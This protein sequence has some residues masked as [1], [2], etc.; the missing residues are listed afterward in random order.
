MA[1]QPVA[2][3]P[4]PDS[5]RD[6]LRVA[7]P[8]MPVILVFSAGFGVLARASGF[9]P[10]A[11]MVM[12]LVAFGGAAQIASVGV[13]AAGGS[14]VGALAV[15]LLVQARYVPMA[16]SMADSWTGPPW[17]R[18]LGAQLLVDGAWVLSRSRRGYRIRTFLGA[19]GAHYVVWN[20]GTVVGLVAGGVLGD[21]RRLG[22]DAVIPAMFLALILPDLRR[23]SGRLAAMIAA[24]AA[25]IAIP[26]LPAGAGY[27]L[28]LMGCLPATRR[29]A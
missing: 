26:L 15:G 9:S 10:E 23:G 13:L 25:L 8:F 4:E 12:S 28:A 22:L 20:L 14:T 21:P 1:V 5:I 29:P 17:R 18:F 19:G 27:L 6:G 2:V 24:A 7:A 11:A 16:L 3:A